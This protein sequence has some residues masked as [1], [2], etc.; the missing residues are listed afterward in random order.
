MSRQVRHAAQA[1]WLPVV[2][3]GWWW[4]TSA[5]STSIYFPPLAKI[6]AVT[7]A[8]LAGGPLPGF[9]AFSL[10]NLAAGLALAIVVGISLGMV[11]GWYPLALR[12]LDPVLQFFRAMPKVALVPLFIGALG[13]GAL[14]KIYSIALGCVWP[15][16]L[17]TIDGVRGVEPGQLEMARA[18]RIPLGLRLRRVILP[19][20]APQ[21]VAGVRVALAIG[22]VVM[23]VSEIYGAQQ[24][25]GYYVLNASRAFD[26]AQTWGGTLLIGLIGYVLST[27][28]VIAE[29]WFLRWHYLRARVLGLN[30]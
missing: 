15:I 23:V 30:A 9:I 2:F 22:V 20:A 12:L 14:P 16:L 25:V 24:G 17:N 19:A 26:V 29:R 18:Y 6:V 27:S 21:I 28:F 3:F 5:G 11:L 8:D 4:W 10:G 7:W 13:I 1:L